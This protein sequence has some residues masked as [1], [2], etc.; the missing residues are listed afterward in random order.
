MMARVQRPDIVAGLLVPASD[1]LVAVAQT[2]SFSA[3]ARALGVRQSTVSRR[4]GELEDRIGVSLF[5]RSGAGIRATSA[6][7][8][9]LNR[10]LQVRNLACTAVEEARDVGAARSGRIRVGFVGSFAT[11]PAK[12]ILGRLR[13][14][15]AGLKIQ[16]AELGT[17]DLIRR[18][19]T[20]ELDCAWIGSW[21][22]PDP[23]LVMEP[24]WTEALYLAQPATRS[25]ERTVTWRDL[26][27]RVLLARPEAELDL[28]QRTLD[29]AGASAPEV[30]FHDCSRESLLAMVADGDGVAILPESFARLGRPGVHFARI[31]EP[32]AAVAICVIY[33]RDRDNP[34]LRRLLAITRDWL[35]DRQASPASPSA[36][37]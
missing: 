14:L 19:V 18:V 32:A 3:A 27:N 16:L 1:T 23:I 7:Q 24:L 34:A 17:T 26:S 35:R 9:L 25:A 2:G 21:R 5:E 36:L 15:H 33:R 22:S 28:L 6:G 13:E 12:E 10:V 29:E 30:R 4:I 31:D 11:S 37:G 20:H 8:Q